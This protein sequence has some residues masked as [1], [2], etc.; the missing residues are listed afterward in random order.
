MTRT[1]GASPGAARHP[2]HTVLVKP[3]DSNWT[4]TF[5]ETLLAQSDMALI[6]EES[7]YKP[8]VY[9]PPNDVR[10]ETMLESSSVTTCP[11]KGEANYF[12]AAI[13]GQ[14]VDIAWQYPIVYDEVEKIAGYIAF[15]EDRV[16]IASESNDER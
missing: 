11:F 1:L 2:M 14:R 6:V 4:V 5:G 9:F 15:Y 16:A 7:G 13:D 8:V 3:S 10:V 12:A